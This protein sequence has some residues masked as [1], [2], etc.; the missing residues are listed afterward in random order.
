M[1]KK[2]NGIDFS[3]S[4]IKWFETYGRNLSFRK[5]KDP[6][7]VWLS[8]IILQQTQ[9]E[10]GLKYYDTFIKK[11]PKIK[12][13][14]EAKEE[15]IYNMWQ[16][17]GYYNRAKNLHKTAI[18]ISEKMGGVFP[19]NYDELLKLP[20]VGRYTAAAISS[21]CYNE[22]KFVVD[23]NVFRVLS[24]YYGINKNISNSNAYSFFEDISLNIGENIKSVGVYNEAIMDFGGS[25]CTSK[26]PNCDKCVISYSCIANRNDKQNFFPI[27]NKRGVKKN[28]YFNYFILENDELFLMQK[29]KQKDIWLNL[30]EFYLLEEKSKQKA[31]KNFL[32]KIKGHKTG[33][34]MSVS[35][36]KKGVLSHQNIHINFFKIFIPNKN[37]L[38]SIKKRLNLKF[39]NKTDI[40]KYA[41]PKVIDN[42]LKCHC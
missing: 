22:R 34:L 19:K 35:N 17:L 31:V 3:N 10:T 14:A 12:D 1:N 23:A 26:K 9:M 2:R 33:K 40:N 30:N 7:S 41:V 5:S 4:L 37:A 18:L 16:G 42:Y 20:G 39:V 6:Y 8:E 25:V 15:E 24:R 11:F 38:S 36:K 32:K 21:I 28:R 27:K 13:L 29:R